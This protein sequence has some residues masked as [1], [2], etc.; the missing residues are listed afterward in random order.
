MVLAV[1]SL[2]PAPSDCLLLGAVYKFA[3]LLTYLLTY[4]PACNSYYHHCLARPDRTVE[5]AIGLVANCH[6]IKMTLVVE[7]HSA[8]IVCE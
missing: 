5:Y 2:L 8:S 7:I 4:L 1:T 6:R 3:Y